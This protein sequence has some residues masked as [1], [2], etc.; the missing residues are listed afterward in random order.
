MIDQ[1]LRKILKEQLNNN[2]NP[3]TKKEIQLFKHLNKNKHKYPKKTDLL[4]FIKT[5]MLVI[6]RPESDARFYYEIYTANY[7]PEGD[8]ENIN[9]L[10]FR[11]FRSFKQRKSP[12]NTAYQYTSAKIPFKGSNLE[13]YWDVN[14]YNNWYYVVKSYGWYPIYLFID[15]NWYRVSNS[16]SSSTAK[17]LSGSN[18][19]RYNS[20]LK[21]NVYL[22]THGEI[23]NLMR[24]VSLDVIRGNR[25]TNFLS[26]LS[27]TLIGKR[28]LISIGWYDNRK[29]VDFTIS[30]IEEHNG[31]IKIYITINKAGKVE[32]IN[33]MVVDPDGY[34]VPSEFSDDLENGIIGKVISEYSDYLSKDNTEFVFEHPK[35]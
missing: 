28:K 23:I 29:K 24:G 27:D 33:K 11:D 14:D 9:K 17:H 5:M 20:G 16:Y 18:P 7:R 15:N 2:E 19:V 30:N 10:T 3:L 22:V 4:D 26:K 13:G 8:Y 1:T 25:V 35:K 31:K 32:G 6:G 34:E 21:A 12:N